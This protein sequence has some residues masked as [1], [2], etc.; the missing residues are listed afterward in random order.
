MHLQLFIKFVLECAF[1]F[2]M[3]FFFQMCFHFQNLKGFVSVF[4]PK[5]TDDYHCF[6]KMCKMIITWPNE[7][8]FKPTA[9]EFHELPK[10]PSINDV[11]PFF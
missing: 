7:L 8:S 3:W 9:I 11:G 10:G 1:T 6:K 2:K 5:D 4:F